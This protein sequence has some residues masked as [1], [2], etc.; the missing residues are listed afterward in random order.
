M[1]SKDWKTAKIGRGGALVF[2][3]STSFPSRARLSSSQAENL[4]IVPYVAPQGANDFALA[5]QGNGL[6]VSARIGRL[7]RELEGKGEI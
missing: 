5:L 7:A 1:Y 4:A 3:F 2:L 6:Q